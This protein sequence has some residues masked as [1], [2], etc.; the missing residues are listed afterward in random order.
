MD[1]VPQGSIFGYDNDDQSILYGDSWEAVGSNTFA[2]ATAGDSVLLYC[3]DFDNDAYHHLGGFISGTWT[4]AGANALDPGTSY[5]YKPD[6]LADTGAIEIAGDWDNLVY[7]GP[8]TGTKANLGK[9]LMD[10]RN[11]QGSNSDRLIYTGGNF[12]ILATETES[13]NNEEFSPQG[14][15]D[16]VSGANGH[17]GPRAKMVGLGSLWLWSMLKL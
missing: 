3:I 6:S 5:S 8:T 7:M 14:E 15:A 10:S 1:L 16:L 11:W 13:V 17:A 4:A 2:L 9:D 12:E